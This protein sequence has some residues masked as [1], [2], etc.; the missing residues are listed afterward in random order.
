M[1]SDIVAPICG[2]TH[3]DKKKEE[4]RA[5]PAVHLNNEQSPFI[6]CFIFGHGGWCKVVTFVAFVAQH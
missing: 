6:D 4:V 3:R 5:L 2:R 1:E